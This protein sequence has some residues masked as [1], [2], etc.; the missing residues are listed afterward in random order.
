MTGFKDGVQTEVLVANLT[1]CCGVATVA[2]HVTLKVGW[3][4]LA[5]GALTLHLASY[6]ISFI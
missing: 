4:M 3:P 1:M 5:A 6:S 2:K